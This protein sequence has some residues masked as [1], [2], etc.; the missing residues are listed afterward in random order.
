MEIKEK[1]QEGEFGQMSVKEIDGNT[2]GN[3]IDCQRK[4]CLLKSKQQEMYE[5]REWKTL[6]SK[7]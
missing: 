6:D 7:G 2:W 1:R 3:V 5:Q 4:N